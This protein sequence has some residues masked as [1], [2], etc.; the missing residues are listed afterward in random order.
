VTSKEEFTDKLRVLITIVLTSSDV[1]FLKEALETV[2][3]STASGQ[4]SATWY[5]TQVE[6]LIASLVRFRSDPTQTS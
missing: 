2:K 4:E 3:S 1:A 5:D 6:N